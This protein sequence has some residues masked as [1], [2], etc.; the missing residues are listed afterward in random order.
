MQK[1]ATAPS[2]SAH[3]Q[4]TDRLATIGTLTAGIAHELNNP[5]GYILSNLTSFS[6]YLPIFVQYF[7]IL[8]ALASCE[9]PEQKTALKQ[10]LAT[11]QQQEDLQFLLQD[12][13]SLLHDSLQ[14]ASRVRDLVLDLRRFSHPDH[15]EFQRLEL[16]PLLEMALRLSKNEL[17]NH[18]TAEYLLEPATIWLQGQPAALTQVLVNLLLNAA[19]AIGGNSGLIRVTAVQTGAWLELCIADSGPGIAP[20]ILPQIFEPFFTTKAPGKGTGLGLPICQSIIQ[21]HGGS[22]RVGSSALGGAAFTL[23]LPAETTTGSVDSNTV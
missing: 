21:Q 4:Q 1:P 10:R 6:L 12:S 8:Q 16:R 13:Q 17:K 18:I 19:Q 20:Q 23:R 11:L 5:I 14:G 7:D 22:I 2:S 9:D 15:A 3:W